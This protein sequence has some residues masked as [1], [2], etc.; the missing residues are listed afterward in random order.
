V[1]FVGLTAEPPAD[2]DTVE[3]YAGQFGIDWPIGLGARETISALQVRAYPTTIVL[4]RDGRVAW[5]SMLRG[6]LDAAI[7]RALAAADGGTQAQ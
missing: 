2:R 7:E 5:N 1:R 4:G 3:R 6:S